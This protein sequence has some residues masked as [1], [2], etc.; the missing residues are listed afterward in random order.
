MHPQDSETEVIKA[1]AS[2]KIEA[3]D[4]LYHQYKKQVYRNI[5]KLVRNS[6]AAEDLL[7]EV[8]ITLWE[9]R[10][11]LQSD[12]SVAGWLF[13]VSHN[14]AQSFLRKKVRESLQYITGSS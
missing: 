6:D 12:R 5:F 9:N 4:A 2:G 14:K 1:L 7:Q 8:F 3:F 11:E 10:S 13:V